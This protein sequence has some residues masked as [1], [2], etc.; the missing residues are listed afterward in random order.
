MR[1]NVEKSKEEQKKLARKVITKDD[2]DEINTVGGVDQAFFDNKIISAIVVCEYPTMKI[3]EQKY[4]VVDAKIPYI[5]G[6]LSYRESPA[7]VEA[8]N[9]LET[10]PDILMVDGHGITH[11]RK[12]GMASHIGLN[13]DIPTIGVA[14]K[15]LVGEVKDDKIYVDN[16]LRGMLVRTREHAKPLIVSI[17]HRISLR[18]AIGVV[19][20]TIMPPHKLPE[21]LHLAHRYADKIRKEQLSH[22]EN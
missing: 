3:V 7:V 6:Y 21:P 20:K 5:P 13:L 15:M 2:F 19:E 1:F 12:L 8:F 10:K 17:G 9:L 4:A 22:T 14:K 18:T 11:P 16:E